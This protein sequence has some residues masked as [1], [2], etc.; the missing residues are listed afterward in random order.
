V[1]LTVSD[2]PVDIGAGIG[3]FTPLLAHWSLAFVV[4]VEP[5]PAMRAEAARARSH[6][7][8]AYAG[9]RA[10]ALPFRT[11]SFTGAWLAFVV[12]HVRDLLACAAELRRVVRVGGHVLIANAFPGRLEGI[13]FPRYFP[14]ARAVAERFP[15]LETVTAAF[16]AVGIELQTL[17]QVRQ[18]TCAS[19]MELAARTRL[20][21]DSTLALISDEQF[22]RGQAAIEQA[23]RD[24]VSEP[25]VDTI[26]L[27]VLRVV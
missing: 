13:T 27:L 25:V 15:T 3:R 5:S 24:A 19:L 6:P 1:A 9:G 2:R 16:A 10:E 17:R 21:S 8:V 11:A 23:A 22:A 26:D 18:P 7:R 4:G 14:E 20:R 12:H